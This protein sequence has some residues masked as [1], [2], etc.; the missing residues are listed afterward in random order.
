MF[1]VECLRGI[2]GCLPELSNSSA[3]AA[4]VGFRISRRT[5]KTIAFAARDSLLRQKLPK[6][7]L[8]AS[9]SGQSTGRG[10]IE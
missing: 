9:L 1:Q 4:R 2:G 5:E 10:R 6:P 3:M 8:S 7:C